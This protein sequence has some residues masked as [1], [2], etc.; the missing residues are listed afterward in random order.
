MHIAFLQWTENICV[1]FDAKRRTK[2]HFRKIA[3]LYH[4]IMTIVR[5]IA[6][7]VRIGISIITTFDKKIS[8]IT[9]ESF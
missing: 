1:F 5:S 7:I 3:V 6:H 2:S 8:L 9:N 4:I